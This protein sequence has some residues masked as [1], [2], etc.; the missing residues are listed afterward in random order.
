MD[1][2]AGAVRH[3]ARGIDHL[4]VGRLLA[5]LVLRERALGL[6][7]WVQAAVVQEADVSGVDVTFQDLQPVAFQLKCSRRGAYE[8][9][10]F[11]IGHRREVAAR[12]HYTST[13]YPPRS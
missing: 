5:Q 11:K 1:P 2:A 6:V 13:R 4:E 9:V 7:F 8:H 12:T 10:G 3:A